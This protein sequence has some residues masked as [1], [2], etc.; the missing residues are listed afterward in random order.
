M[1]DSSLEWLL[2]LDSGLKRS[3]SRRTLMLAQAVAGMFDGDQ[4]ATVQ[5]KL[6]EDS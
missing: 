1:L 5:Q 2:L 4:W 6:I 3:E